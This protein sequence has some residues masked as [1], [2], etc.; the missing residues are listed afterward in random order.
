MDDARDVTDLIAACDIADAGAVDYSLEEVRNSWRQPTFDLRTDALVVATTSGRLVGYVGVWDEQH[1]RINAEGYVHPEYRGRGIGTYLLRWVEPRA[2]EMAAL[3]PPGMRVTLG[4]GIVGAN[5]GAARL[6]EREG[7]N[8]VRTYWHMRAAMDSPPPAPEWPA[9]IVVRAFVP[10]QDDYALYTTADE[11][12]RDHWDHVSIPFEEWR[13]SRLNYEGFDP[14]L[15]FLAL[16]GEA[17]AG[18]IR[19]RYRLADGWV[20]NLSVRRPWRGRGLGTAL[21]WH[22]FGEFYRRGARAVGLGVDSENPT[23]ATRLYE[24][25]GMRVDRRYDVYHKILRE[26]AAPSA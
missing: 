22:A 10:G 9:G 19:C 4:H 5:D 8:R 26:G 18:A 24:R 12:F 13:E 3:A 16:D 17:V 1:V 6:L 21:L 20:D 14:T 25:A 11:A 15:C 23:G 7:Y 2:R